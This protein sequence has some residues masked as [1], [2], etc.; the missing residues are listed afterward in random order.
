MGDLAWTDGSGATPRG[1]VH[2]LSHTVAHSLTKRT[3]WLA[4]GVL[5][6][7]CLL[8]APC[9]AEGSPGGSNRAATA[10]APDADADLVPDPRAWA[11][12]T[13]QEQAARRAELQRR[14]EAMTPAERQVLRSRIRE[15]IEQLS[16]AERKALAGQT[17]QQWHALPVE[18]RERLVRERRER[19]QAM[20][21]EERRQLQQQRRAIL[22]KLTPEEREALRAPL[23]PR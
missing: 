22:D 5:V 8:A 11:T 13:P 15:R 4:I 3:Q 9:R 10:G 2:P 6:A 14:L 7:S 17:R 21:P 19:I 16:P 20:T 1:P 23:P 18:E 12:L